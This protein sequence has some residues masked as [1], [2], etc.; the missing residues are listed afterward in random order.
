MANR[1]A[2]NFFIIYVDDQICEIHN[3]SI[4]L[5]RDYLQNSS[6]YYRKTLTVFLYVAIVHYNL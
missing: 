2:T 6:L 5:Y 3:T 4:L 1:L